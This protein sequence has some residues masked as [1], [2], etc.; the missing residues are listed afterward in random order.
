[1]PETNCGFDSVPG[2]ATGAQ[3]LISM[4]PTIL[5]DIG[6]DKNPT[7]FPPKPGIQGVRALVDTGATESC[8][9]DLLATQLNL[10]A[11][12][13]RPVGGSGGQHMVNMYLAQIY[14]PSLNVSIIGAFAG[15]HLEAGGQ[16]HRAL[17]GR[18]FLQNLI[19]T[20]DGKSGKVV[21]KLN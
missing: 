9:D 3:L 17:I 19:M 5:V 15:L 11:F 12:D 4:G 16:I 18:T 6:F 2:G 13:K 10:P 1:M 20:Y 21:L 7:G 14:I 8:I